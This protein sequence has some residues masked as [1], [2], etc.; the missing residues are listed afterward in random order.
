MPSSGGLGGRWPPALSSEYRIHGDETWGSG[1]ADGGGH[2]GQLTINT[3][4]SASTFPT[5]T[6]VVSHCGVVAFRLTAFRLISFCLIAPQ[7]GLLQSPNR[8]RTRVRVRVRVRVSIRREMRLD[9]MR[10]HP[11]YTYLRSAKKLVQQKMIN[12]KTELVKEAKND[13]A[14]RCCW[15]A[16]QKKG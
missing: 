15:S 1:G 4:W 16:Y 10:R 14:S 8:S 2:L 7:L 13:K 12:D 9:E 6:Q 11:S 5:Q 3:G